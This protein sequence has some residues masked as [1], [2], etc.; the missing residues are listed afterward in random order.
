MKYISILFTF[1]TAISLPIQ[2]DSPLTS[3]E[4]HSAYEN[5]ALVKSALVGRL[6][7]AKIAAGLSDPGIA[8]DVKA[9]CVNALG[10]E[11]HARKNEQAFSSYLMK[12][13]AGSRELDLYRLHN[14][15]LTCL[16]YLTALA[17]Y[18]QLGDAASLL[19]MSRK[20]EPDNFTVAI[21][22]A[23]I[24][25]QSALSGDWCRVWKLTEEVVND[26]SLVE[27]KLRTPALKVIVDYMSL[28]KD[29]CP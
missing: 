16:W 14:D 29:S 15:E 22:F 26:T 28:Y 7:T 2:A 4:F 1:L 6:L 3:T 25:A 23:L 17:D 9:A 19:D 18:H 13:Y 24:Q 21:I 20:Q 27:D 8:L 5:E 11:R 12:K 10:W